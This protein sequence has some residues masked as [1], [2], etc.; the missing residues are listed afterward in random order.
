MTV[1]E[2]INQLE[3]L[4]KDLDVCFEYQTGW[5]DIN[6]VREDN[7]TDLDDKNEEIDIPC[8]VLST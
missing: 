7:D 4:P 6:R 2:L 5:Y 3:K 1:K 8:I